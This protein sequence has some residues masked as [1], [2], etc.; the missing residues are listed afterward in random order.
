MVSLNWEIGHSIIS[1]TYD[2]N[3]MGFIARNNEIS[4]AAFIGYNHFE[5]FGNFLRMGGGFF[6]HIDYLYKYQ[7]AEEQQVR[8]NLFTENGFDFSWNAMTKDFFQIGT[9]VYFR[10]SPSYDYFEPR[11]DGRYYQ[12]PGFASTRLNLTTYRRKTL[13]FN[14]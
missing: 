6:T 4:F 2:P 10:P 1:D 8:D 9:S 7:G 5:P 3:D 13:V 12:T 11:V 14:T